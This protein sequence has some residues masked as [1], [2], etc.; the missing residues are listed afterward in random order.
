MLS[1]THAH[2]FTPGAI[3]SFAVVVIVDGVVVVIIVI[4]EEKVDSPLAFHK[5]PASPTSRCVN[6]WDSSICKAFARW[7]ILFAPRG[8]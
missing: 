6:S 3:P 2:P 8:D 1:L 4:V 5:P 7:L